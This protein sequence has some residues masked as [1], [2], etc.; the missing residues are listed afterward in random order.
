MTLPA[1]LGVRDTRWSVAHTARTYH[2]TDA[3]DLQGEKKDLLAITTERYQLIV[4][5]FD[6]KG[7]TIVTKAAG[8]L[9]V[10]V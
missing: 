2:V 5:S 7:K 4:L 9:R 3:S 6:N 10:G 1:Q 8:D